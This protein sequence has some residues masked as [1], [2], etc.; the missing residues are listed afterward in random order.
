MKEYE[1][2]ERALI[3]EAEKEGIHSFAVVGGVV[4]DRK[5]LLVRRSLDDF[6][7]GIWELPGG[8]VDADESIHDA[9]R[10]ELVEE[11]G[12]K[13]ISILGMFRGFDYTS[14]SDKLTRQ[15]NFAVIAEGEEIVLHDSEHIE[16]A[17]VSSED[18]ENNNIKLTPEISNCLT[19]F[20]DKYSK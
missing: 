16:Y 7:G 18:L 20:F 13:L 4:R 5:V 2:P 9:L 15:F 10:R 14:D 12:L 11:T 1:I 6:L 8:G 17:W 19:D 3:D